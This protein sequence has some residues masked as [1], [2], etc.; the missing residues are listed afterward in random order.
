MTTQGSPRYEIDPEECYVFVRRATR[1]EILDLAS[2]IL[3]T[4]MRRSETLQNPN[5]AKLYLSLQMGD[6]ER[7]VFCCMFLDNRHRVIAFEKP[8]LG[9]I[10]GISVHPRE[11][12]K[13]A[14]KCN[15]AAVIF[16]HNHPSGVAEPSR[17]DEALTKQLKDALALVGIQVLDHIVVAGTDTVSLAERG[18]L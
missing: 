15:A 11:V 12:L 10:D 13:A 3:E 17:A 1:K 4:R 16:A 5:E 18:M 14:L 8:F 9:T 7:E 2:N 6:L